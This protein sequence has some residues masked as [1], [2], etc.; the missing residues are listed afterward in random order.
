[1]T[2]ASAQNIRLP[3]ELDNGASCKIFGHGNQQYPPSRASIYF[4]TTTMD[5]M[6][7]GKL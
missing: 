7:A 1:M 3:V 4:R 2:V 5:L 6:V